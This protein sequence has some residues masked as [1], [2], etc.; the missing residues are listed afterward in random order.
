MEHTLP[1]EDYAITSFEKHDSSPV[2]QLNA[3]KY[4]RH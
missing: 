4:H 2:T 1:L 3:R